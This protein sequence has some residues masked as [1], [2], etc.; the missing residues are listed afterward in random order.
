MIYHYFR[1]TGAHDTVLDCAD[2]FSVT[3][4]DVNIQEF[5]TRCDEILLSMSKVP[6]DDVLESLYKLRIRESVQLKTVLELYDM[7][8]HQ[9]ISVPNYQKFKTMVMRSID[10]KIRLRNFDARHGRLETGAVVKNRNGLLMYPFSFS[11]RDRF[12]FFWRGTHRSR[13]LCGVDRIGILIRTALIGIPFVG[14]AFSGV[15]IWMDLVPLFDHDKDFFSPL[16]GE[17]DTEFLD[18][19][20]N[21]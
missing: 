1:V 19:E 20:K 15:L 14:T 6:S 16:C 17:E 11:Y 9:K 4:H 18:F 21:C 3:L 2:L 8:I 13:L 7:E 10:Q 5:D 12:W